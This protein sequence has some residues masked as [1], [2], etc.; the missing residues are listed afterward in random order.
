MSIRQTIFL[1]LSRLI[2]KAFTINM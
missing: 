2:S 1:F